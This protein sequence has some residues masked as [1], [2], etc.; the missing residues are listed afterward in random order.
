VIICG[1][2]NIAHKKIDIH[3]WR[4]HQNSPGFLAHE[5]QWMDDLLNQI[6][7]IDTYREVDRESGRY[8]WWQDEQHRQENQG[9]RLDYQ[10]ATP[11]VRHTVL[12]AGIY[13]H[14]AFS[15]HAPVIIDYDWELH[16]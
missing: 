13:T 9:W 14:K 5:R 10:V 16:S 6:G 2:W 8:T 1:G 3:D 12:N 11:G 15:K 7:L 4:Y